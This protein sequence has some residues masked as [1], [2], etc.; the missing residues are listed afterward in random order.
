MIVGLHDSDNTGFPNLAL[1][2]ISAWHKKQGDTVKWYHP[3]FD[4]EFSKIYS[5]KIFTFTPKD[6]Y[7]P[8]DDRVVIGGTG[9]N[10]FIELDHE[11]EHIMPDYSLY[12][13]SFA[14]G[15]VTRGCIRK[16]PWCV[17]PKKE[18][19]IRKHASIE[20][21]L[22]GRKNL[23]LMDNNILAHSH[24]IDELVKI[25]KLRI[26]LDCNQ[27]MD[28][29]LVDDSIAK[30]LASIKWDTI[31]FACD[32]KSQMESVK[33]AVETIRKYSGKKG[34]FSIYVLVKDID[35]AMDR[36][37]FLKEL[38]CDPFAQPYRDF[39]NNEQP[40][41]ILKKFARWVNFKAIF[42]SVKWE[43]YR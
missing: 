15:F 6:R 43:D 30:I 24:G 13:S 32:Q 42:K 39:Q 1:M 37:M 40:S 22:G 7:L 9:Y 28:A 19:E 8:D 10:N 2:K 41:E 12:F 29:R 33:K 5:S 27:G 26:K 18:G 4:A 21:F 35:D 31:R 11:I 23:V 3:L 16:C 36:V 14:Q 20:E 34:S 25:S 38:G 17:V